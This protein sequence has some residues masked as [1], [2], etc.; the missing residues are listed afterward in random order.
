MHNSLHKFLQG[1]N[2]P[3]RNVRINK[4]PSIDFMWRLV[5]I[6][7]EALSSPNKQCFVCIPD[8]IPDSSQPF[9]LKCAPAFG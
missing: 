6:P 3:K 2:E 1:L 4:I 8:S 7:S 5:W 9:S